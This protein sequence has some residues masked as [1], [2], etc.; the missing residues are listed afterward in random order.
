[1]V[2]NFAIK[3]IK[4][5][6]DNMFRDKVEPVEGSVLYSDLYFAVEHS[7]IYIGNNQISNIVVNGF[8]ESTVKSSSPQSFV[9]GGWMHNK[10]YISCD[11]SGAVGDLEVSEYAE[12]SVGEKAFYGLVF[13]NCHEFSEKCL[14]Q[15]DTTKKG[16]IQ[17]DVDLFMPN[18][19][20]ERT[21]N[22]LKSSAKEQLGAT[23]WR[24]WDAGNTSSNEG[25]YPNFGEFGDELYDEELNDDSI[26]ELGKG[27]KVLNEYLKEISDENIPNKAIKE[28]ED[29]KEKLKKVQKKYD[30]AKEFIQ[31]MEQPFSYN[32][33]INIKNKD[34]LKLTKQLKSNKKIKKIIHKLGN[35]YIS[36]KKK[37]TQSRQMPNEL[38]GVHKSNDLSRVFPSELLG[39]DDEDLEYLFYAK[40][41]ESNLLSYELDGENRSVDNSKTKGPI[42]VCFDSSGSMKGKPILKAR[43]LLFSISKILKK[44]NREMYILMFGN[45]NQIK[46][47][48][49][50]SSDNSRKLLQ[51][52]YS[53]FDGGTNFETPLNRSFEIIEDKKEF[54]NA[55]IL[56]VTDGRCDISDDFKSKLLNKKQI[57]GFEIYTII[58]HGEIISDNYSSE[59]IGI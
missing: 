22:S 59:I 29:Y 30:E 6:I 47:I 56:M 4:Y 18:E 21:L 25:L 42:V 9:D 5:W 50:N 55:D 38:H 10:I 31:E 1:M 45:Q 16:N 34:F 51:F 37:E 26:D 33:L 12:N 24:L 57:L 43:A 11:S 15:S 28:I 23:K 46:E 35:S 36:E 2:I 58:C 3:T 14:Y 40:Y 48:H 54:E 7:G 20:W 8:M 41:L 32:D 13:S 52:L 53:L 49:V 27:E 17:F 44:E 39:I 19:T